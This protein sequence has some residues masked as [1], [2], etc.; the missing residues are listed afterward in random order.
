MALDGLI[1]QGYLYGGSSMQSLIA[2]CKGESLSGV[3]AYIDQNA[4]TNYD[5]HYDT[6]TQ[7]YSFIP[8]MGTSIVSGLW[9]GYRSV[10]AQRF[11]PNSSTNK[12]YNCAEKG[13]C[14][15]PQR[16]GLGNTSSAPYISSRTQSFTSGY[17]YTLEWSSPNI[18]LKQGSTTLTTL[19][20][21]RCVVIDLVA[22]GGTGGG[23]Y[24][25]NPLTNLG[26]KYTAGGGGG[27]AGGAA[28][29]LVDMSKATKLTFDASS[30]AALYVKNSSGTTF[31]TLNRGASGSSG[32]N[33]GYGTGGTGGTVSKGTAPTGVSIR[34]TGQNTNK[35][36][37]G[38]G[39]NGS[40]GSC[41]GTGGGY[42]KSKVTFLSDN[43]ASGKNGGDGG[44]SKSTSAAGGG[45]CAS[46]L[47][48]GGQGKWL[49]GSPDSPGLGGGGGGAYATTG[50]TTTS[51]AA[52]GNAGM[53][54]YYE[55]SAVSPYTISEACSNYDSGDGPNPRNGYSNGTPPSP[56][57]GGCVFAGTRIAIDKDNTI[58]I[59][60]YR[61]NMQIDYCDPDTLEHSPQQTLT[62]C[63]IGDSRRKITLGLEDG[64]MLS[65]TA[66]HPIL[67]KDGFKS[68]LDGHMFP[69]YKLGELIATVD[70]YKELTSIQDEPIDPT[71]VYN[72]ITEKDT[73]VANGFIVGGELE[74][75]TDSISLD[76]GFEPTDSN[77]PE[78]V[79]DENGDTP[80]SNN[81]ESP[82]IML[83][84][85]RALIDPGM[86][87][88][89]V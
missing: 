19:T 63:F 80:D 66:N 34:W 47:G 79:I 24:H 44:E 11:Q 29:I 51:G 67:T 88:K 3:S 52:G 35:G 32:N 49:N 46:F 73:M 5:E 12:L 76:R 81:N 89:A 70:G 82:G 2:K 6:T 16:Y 1:G 23:S 75:A 48:V 53:V 54:I 78:E 39:I 45:G 38:G 77:E 72:L 30:D 74:F 36:G 55:S 71:E 4:D 57:G 43:W 31:L 83:M 28:S 10:V 15:I 37:S 33:K 25:G 22:R 61:N 65:V 86:S 84:S 26:I 50:G 27:G 69:K 9:G 14:P 18:I 87:K 85:S 13:C 64:K 56:S 68:Y 59:I 7:K 60:E 20:N 42:F 21:I 58:D 41:G 62:Y 17:T 40:S 8:Y